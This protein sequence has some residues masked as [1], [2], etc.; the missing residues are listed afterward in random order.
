MELIAYEK[1]IKIVA[2]VRNDGMISYV[3]SNGKHMNEYLILR[4]KKEWQEYVQNKR[5][6]K[7]KYEI[8]M[9][10]REIFIEFWQFTIF[11]KERRYPMNIK[12]ISDG[13]EL[14][15][16]EEEYYADAKEVLGPFVINQKPY[17]HEGMTVG[18]Y[19]EEREYYRNNWDKV[20]NRT[21]VPLWKQKGQGSRAE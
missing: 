7:A 17:V 10:E 9:I 3:T 15:I 5:I 8:D 18:E 1:Q 19:Y 2:T 14:E 13:I 4:Y 6:E 20:R 11:V 21:Y 16:P 12:V